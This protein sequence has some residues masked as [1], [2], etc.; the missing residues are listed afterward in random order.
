M[1]DRDWMLRVVDGAVGLLRS[2]TA[3]RRA[4]FMSRDIR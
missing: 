3:Y 4:Y 1:K 2:L